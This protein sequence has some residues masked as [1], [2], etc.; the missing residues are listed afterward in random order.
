MNKR[1]FNLFTALI[2]FLLILLAVLLVQSMIQAERNATDTVDHIESRSKLEATS[3]MARADAMQV[4]NYALRKKIEDW[5]VSP[6]TGVVFL[7]LEDKSWEE[8]QDDF[9]ESKFGG[10][11]GSQFAHFTAGSLEAIFHQPS[12]FGNYTIS[13]EGKETLAEGIKNAIAKSLEDD[14]FTVIE[15]N[16][17]PRGNNCPLGTFYVNLHL[18]RLTQQEYENLPKIVVT[19]KASGEELKQVILPKTTFRIYVPLRF[20]KAIAEARSLAHYSNSG[21]SFENEGW[22]NTADDY[23]LFAPKT[24]NEI[25]QFALGM[26]D[27]SSC[28]PREDPLTPMA[29]NTELPAKTGALN[30]F[31]PGDSTA[32]TWSTT[33]ITIPITG[34]YAWFSDGDVPA[35]YNANNNSGWEK[36]QTALGKVAEAR[37]CAVIKGAKNAGYLDDVADDNFA[38]VGEE[39]DDSGTNLAFD[40]AINVQT[41]ESK[42]IGGGAKSA[43]QGVNPGRNIG[44]FGAVDNVQFPVITSTAMTCS[45]NQGDYKSRCAEVNSVKVVLAFEETDPNYMVR[46]PKPGRER[47]YRIAIFDN[48]YKPFTANWQQGNLGGN[49]LYSIAPQETMC[50][51]APGQGWN[52]TT[53][54]TPGPLGSPMTSGCTP[55]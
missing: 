13:I 17:D 51:M 49:D 53:I 20:F 38:M 46:R 28:K 23:G 3:E 50:S 25:E 27:Y 16:G 5:L 15:C 29:I 33:D 14:F 19:D 21:K 41:G 43:A 54:G 42:L 44:L 39:C 1:G 32:P 47:L 30:L 24:H 7:K 26:C 11:Q 36:M 6:E 2:S 10:T 9:A 34:N 48:T 37:V 12:H 52:C 4:F 35:T 45:S 18:E 40:I 8:I 22:I 31:C 55:G